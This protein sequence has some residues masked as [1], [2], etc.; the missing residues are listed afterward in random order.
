M[1]VKFVWGFGL[2]RKCMVEGFVFVDFF[3]CDISEGSSL[4]VGSGWISFGFICS[5]LLVLSVL[6]LV[7][8]CLEGCIWRMKEVEKL[9][10][11]MG[12][13]VVW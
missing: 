12:V 3:L 13:I 9:W 6:N 8:R 2:G 1:I 5:V 7:L 10:V 4:F 11:M